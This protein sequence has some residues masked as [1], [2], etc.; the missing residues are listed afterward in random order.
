MRAPASRNTALHSTKPYVQLSVDL[1]TVYQTK[2]TV[3][4]EVRKKQLRRSL[5]LYG[6]RFCLLT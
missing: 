6:L 4:D 5:N 3:N 2:R 1:T